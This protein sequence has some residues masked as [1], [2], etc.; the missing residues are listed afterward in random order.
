MEIA[1]VQ[2]IVITKLAIATPLVFL[3]KN[4]WQHD[5]LKVTKTASNILAGSLKNSPQ[6]KYLPLDMM[7]GTKATRY[8]RIY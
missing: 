5:A 8:C 4:I 2:P 6:R 1:T 7:Q 3:V